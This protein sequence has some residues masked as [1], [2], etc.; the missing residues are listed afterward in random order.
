M[1]GAL[2]ALPEWL[3]VSLC[4]AC[5]RCGCAGRGQGQHLVGSRVLHQQEPLGSRL[6]LSG[7]QGQC[8]KMPRGGKLHLNE[9]PQSQN[10]E[11]LPTSHQSPIDHPD[12]AG[13]LCGNQVPGEAWGVREQEEGLNRCP[14]TPPDFHGARWT[15]AAFKAP[16]P[17][18]AACLAPLSPYTPAP[19]AKIL[20]PARLQL[21]PAVQALPG[22]SPIPQWEGAS[23]CRSLAGCSF[24][25]P[26]PCSWAAASPRLPLLA[27]HRAP[28][29]SLG[30]VTIPRSSHPPTPGTWAELLPPGQA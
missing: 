8:M 24:S 29:V 25:D 23:L 30:V 7:S 12:L 15:R 19:S 20:L 6:R 16:R 14:A 2:P 26:G 18:R 4:L 5:A 3:G 1:L 11:R 27:A 17:A 21:H 9:S 10:T 13:G 22:P 28:P